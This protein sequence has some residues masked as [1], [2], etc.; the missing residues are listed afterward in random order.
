MAVTDD[1]DL[2]KK[3]AAFQE[4]A[5]N[6]SD[7][8]T[9]QQLLHPVLMDKL[10][11]PTYSIFGKHLLVLFQWLHILSKAIHWKEKRGMRPD[12]FPKRLPDKLAAWR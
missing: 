1:Q 10:I 2:A 6:P 9:F 11:L 8:W 4:K 3:I 7:R 5:G 12:Y